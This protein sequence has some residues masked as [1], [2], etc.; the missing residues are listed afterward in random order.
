MMNPAE[1]ILRVFASH[2]RGPASLRLMGGA[3][4][5]LGY[6][7]ERSTED[8]D[9]L[10]LDSE[11]ESMIEAADFGAALEATNRELEPHGLYFSHIWGP[12]QQILTPE[13]RSS[14]RSIDRDWG[15][16][17]LTV[18]T[19]GPLDLIL[20]KLCRADD[21]DLEDI[22]FLIAS[23]GVEKEALEKALR[24]AVVPPDFAEVF[25]PHGARALALFG[26]SATEPGG[27]ASS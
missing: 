26:V 22:N 14:C 23:Q 13:W 1:R 10:Q 2:L 20:S 21:G 12:E 7:R 27:C 19:L 24:R 5:I 4:L 16:D 8:V 25:E 15:S 9:V 3:A 6:G 11:V 17:R 18:T